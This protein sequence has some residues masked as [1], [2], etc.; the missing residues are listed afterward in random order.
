MPRTGEAR[1]GESSKKQ[2][3]H[4]TTARVPA[5]GVGKRMRRGQR[6]SGETGASCGSGGTCRAWLTRAFRRSGPDAACARDKTTF[7]GFAGLSSASL[8]NADPLV[9]P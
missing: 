7:A 3:P 6:E 2:S 1:E 8:N 5:D 4:Y 9:E